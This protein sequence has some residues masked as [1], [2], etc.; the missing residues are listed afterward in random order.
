MI[1][2][3]F[4]RLT[5]LRATKQRAKSGVIIWVC[6]CVCGVQHN[7][8]TDALTTG[9]IK[10]CG[11]LM[12]ETSAKLGRSKKVHG[13]TGTAIYNCWKGMKD[14][15]HNTK[16]KKYHRWGGRGIKV[17]SRWLNSF[18]NFYDDMGVKP[19]HTSLDRIDND[20]N[21]TPE[22]CRWVD[23]MVQ[24]NNTRANHHI[25]T[26]K[27]LMTVAEASRQFGIATSTLHTRIK[28]GDV[29]AVLFRKAT[30]NGK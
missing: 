8:R 5:V 12:R 17:C 16:N 10:S 21:Y 24:A 18:Q 23:V 22:N 19:A 27:G 20:G 6:R 13:M 7:V 14:R 29:G 9:S 26:P 4:N 15:C 28:K 1:G 30:P 3:Q 25:E 11:C 2:R